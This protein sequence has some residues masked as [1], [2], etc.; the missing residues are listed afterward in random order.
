VARSFPIAQIRNIG[1]MA[2]IDA[3]KTT[4]TERVLFYTGVSRKMGEVH[5]GTAQ[6]DWME[7]EQ[8]R[9]ITI[10]A[11]STTCFWRDH[12]IN[13][14]DTPGHVDF[15]I[16]VERS[17]RVLD[18]AVALF[19][20]VGGVEPQS[21][22][23][24][25]QA[26]RYRVPRIAFINK[27]DR[28]GA[29]PDRCVQEI[30]ERLRANP[31][32]I[33]IPNALED[34]FSGVVDLIDMKLVAWEDDTLG[35]TP[36]VSDIPD[37][38]ADAA[39]AARASMIEAIA[40]SDDEA[41]RAYLEER[42]PDGAFLRAA[43]RRATIAGRAVPVL[44]GAAFKN[45][46]VQPLLDAVVDFLP[47]P[48]DV[49]AVPGKDPAGRPTVRQADDAE[50][51]SALA[52]KIMNDANDPFVGSLT[53]FRVYSGKVAS[54]ATV[55][56][57]VKG[58]REKIGRLLRMHANK[59]EDV[60]EVTT[61]NIAAAAGL[62]VTTTGD[63]LCDEAAPVVLEVMK[64]PAPVISIA[65]EPKTQAT[66]DKLG[67]ALAKLAVE[68]P[69]FSVKTDPETGQ[70]II[71]GMGE[72]HLEIIVDRL[73]REFKIEASVGRPQVAYR[74]TIA[75]EADAEG[76]YIRQTGGRGAYGHVSLHVEPAQGKGIVFEDATVGGSV[77]PE[78]VP[79]VERGV[80]E[81]LSRG[82]MAGYPMIDVAVK[83]TGGSYHEIDSSEK[84]FQIAGSMGAQAAAREAGPVLLEPLMQVEVLTPD[85]FMGEVTGNLSARRGR[86]SG[87]EARG[88]AQAITAEVPLASM[89]GYSTDVRSMTQGRATYT[90]QFSRYAPVP[91]HVTES[92]V[93]RMRGAY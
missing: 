62:R 87:M 23:V 45:K 19:C 18:G 64:F 75:R 27:C 31:I 74:E 93:E 68:D 80:R 41:M 81:T 16:E 85:E 78:F 30:R 61:G 38:L 8:E 21:E 73:V 10:T 90:M 65:I 53:Y 25:R 70:T 2:H 15:T 13:V 36:V 88:S 24:W 58:K 47:S 76:K 22:T 39:A 7:Q 66:Q 86:V 60:K 14:I 71:S 42:Q 11:A 69:S 9:G 55:Y 59:R 33:Q 26:D 37:E 56:N 79:A 46:G 63:T 50:P 92:I 28:V 72:L 89:F 67:M 1:I 40:E 20:A 34:E 44:L 49:P 51:F 12:R 48:I 54:G 29:E 84:A 83:L 52:F 91:T 57:A 6:M 4:T 77:P 3:G 32:V 43:L 17:L 35:A 82:V 5:E